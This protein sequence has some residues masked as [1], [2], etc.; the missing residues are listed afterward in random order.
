MK[1]VALDTETTGV[2]MAKGH[3]IISV[4]LVLVDGYHIVGE[5]EFIVDPQRP[6]E[7]GA[8]AIHGIT[9]ADVE[10]LPT[11]NELSQEIRGM[12]GDRV[13]VAHNAQF[14]M[15]YLREEISLDNPAICTYLMS[16]ARY[17]NTKHSLNALCYRFGISTKHRTEH[18]ALLDA[19]L[20]L[21]CYAR[22]LAIPLL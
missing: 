14:D 22:M 20:T 15:G 9:D 8:T 21:E 2:D 13:V 6:I 1:I 3:K 5:K 17:T 7:E 19:K 18:G 12:I 10:G 11:M 16:K 4:G